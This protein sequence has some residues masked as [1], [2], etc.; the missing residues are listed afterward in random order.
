MSAGVGEGSSRRALSFPRTPRGFVVARVRLRFP[1]T[2]W[3]CD[4]L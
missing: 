2:P 1:A 4:L 3:V